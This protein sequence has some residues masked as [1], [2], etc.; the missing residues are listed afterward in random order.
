M[1]NLIAC[2]HPGK[3]GD[4]LYAL[5][6]IKKACEINNCKA[7]FYTSEY[8]RP[9][10]RLVKY[11][12]YIDEFIIPKNYVVERMDMGVQPYIMPID[13]DKYENVYQMG[14][15]WVPDRAIPDFIALTCGIPLPVKVE[16]EYPESLDEDLDEP[17]II[18]A[19]RGETG[20]KE[21]FV[22]F[23]EA[24]PIPCIVVGGK[25][26]FIGVGEDLTGIDMLETTTWIA[27]SA[28]FLGLMSSQL[29]LANGFNIPKIAVHNGIN[30]D[31]R[32]VIY[33]DT[34]FYPVN[35][36][37]LELLRILNL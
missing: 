9:M 23:I 26:D 24:C 25:G 34:N 36:S 16:Y 22:K 4:A 15:R 19:P 7:D 10:E 14:F 2:S 6:A 8:C 3:M 30:W 5:P 18:I 1:T 27:K 31:M 32:H 20:F 29:A 21:L 37:V 11:Q 33:S 28:G 12:S 13:E 35:P 17:Y